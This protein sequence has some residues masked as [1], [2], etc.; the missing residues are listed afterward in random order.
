MSFDHEIRFLEVAGKHKRVYT[1]S[2]KLWDQDLDRILD[3]RADAVQPQA[4][5]EISNP[6]VPDLWHVY[7]TGRIVR[8]DGKVDT[9]EGAADANAV[10]RRWDLTRLLAEMASQRTR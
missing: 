1:I 7:P 5:Y 3:Y 2:I 10:R 8:P 6:G 9:Y 4:D